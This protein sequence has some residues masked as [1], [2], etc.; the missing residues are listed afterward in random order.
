LSG[1]EPV[2]VPWVVVLAFVR[3]TTHPT[4]CQNPMSISMAREA[5]ESWMSLPTVRMLGPSLSTLS[6]FF[7]MLETADTGGNLSTDA[8]IAATAEEHGGTV[9]SNDRDFD[10]FPGIKRVNP[11]K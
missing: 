7:D 8:L 4:I 3:L 2:G 6:R 9:Y 1:S 11:I 5:V 10:R